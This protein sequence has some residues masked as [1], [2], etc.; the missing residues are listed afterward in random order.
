MKPSR[1]RWRRLPLL[2]ALLA[3]AVPLVSC[4]DDTPAQPIVVVTPAPVRGV[5]AQTSF[6]GF[7]SGI[8]VA[9]EIIVSQTGEVD[10][11]VDWTFP[12][13]WIYVYFG[14]VKC[15]YAQLT[16]GAC[17]FLVASETQTPKPRFFRTGLLEPG[18]YY[19]VL[20]NVA[21][22]PRKGIG[23]DNTEAVSIQLGLTVYPFTSAP[24]EGT[25]SV[26]RI[27]PLTPPRL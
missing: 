6:S 16:S 11:N 24:G 19:L 17:P 21:R 10:T 9:I 5:L 23:S 20:Q 12:D 1:E 4:E 3:L 2:V 25:I 15:D 13:S 7:Q 8:W 18:T 27:Q 22:D 26:G 14:K